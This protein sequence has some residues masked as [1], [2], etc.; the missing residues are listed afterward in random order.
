MPPSLW[1]PA[2][3]LLNIA[4]PGRLLLRGYRHPWLPGWVTQCE[5]ITAGIV[6]NKALARERSRARDTS[7][8]GRYGRRA[9]GRT[10]RPG[11]IPQMRFYGSV[12]PGG[13]GRYFF[14]GV[15]GEI[16]VAYDVVATVWRSIGMDYRTSPDDADE[17]TKHAMHERRHRTRLRSE[18]GSAGIFCV[19]DP[20]LQSV[21]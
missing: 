14:N 9:R 7:W 19:G 2:W 16:G 20:C 4:Q 11:Q 13:S 15:C 1:A 3:F 8:A 18:D 12:S 21:Q 17:L 5:Y 6:R 10:G